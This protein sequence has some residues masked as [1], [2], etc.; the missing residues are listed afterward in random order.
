MDWLLYYHV[1]FVRVSEE[2]PVE[3]RKV[4]I[5]KETTDAE[6]VIK[7]EK[8]L[9]SDFSVIWYR[10]GVF[11]PKFTSVENFDDLTFNLNRQLRE[12]ARTVSEFVLE[13][14]KY[15]FTINKQEDLGL[16]KLSVLEFA[17]T[18]GLLIPATIICEEK[19][20]LAKFMKTHPHVITKNVSQGVFVYS[21][22][23][24]LNSITEK[25]TPERF[26]QLKPKFKLSMF[27][28]MIEKWIELRIFY[29][30][31]KFFTSAIFS[32]NDPKTEVDFRNY[33]FANPNRT[34]PFLLPKDIQEKLKKLMKLA[35]L[36]SGSIDMIISKTGQYYFLE[37]NPI[38]QFY[39][40]SHPCNYYLEKKLAKTIR[41]HHEKIKK[42]S[43]TTGLYAIGKDR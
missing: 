41:H 36:N 28:E 24:I 12:E 18:V 14:M 21:E 20:I 29:L 30:H 19:T 6:V 25:I 31:G 32:Q 2:E 34:P 22:S 7:N 13:Q 39:Q 1:D 42:Q 27:Q 4:L 11:T 9:L 3:F 26:K 15:K 23:H 38:G 43:G 16:N 33:N 8:H 37:V 5:T 17:K 40:V 35:D 10:R